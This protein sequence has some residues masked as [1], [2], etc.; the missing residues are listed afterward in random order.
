[1]NLFLHQEEQWFYVVFALLVQKYSLFS[2]IILVLQSI[3]FITSVKI[4]IFW[5]EIKRN[6]FI[7]VSVLFYF[8]MM[9]NNREESSTKY[10]RNI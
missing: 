4:R 5:Y 10:Y 2:Y 6:I 8:S 9:Y 7:H 1:L 3:P